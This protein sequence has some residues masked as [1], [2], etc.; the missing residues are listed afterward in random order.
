MRAT[1]ITLIQ[2]P[3]RV[4]TFCDLIVGRWSGVD[5]T[6]PL[7]GATPCTH[8]LIWSDDPRDAAYNTA[9]RNRAHDHSHERLFRADPLYDLIGVLDYNSDPVVRGAG[10]AIFL[11]QWRKPRHP[12]EG[13]VAFSRANLRY[14]L[15]TWTPRSRVIIRP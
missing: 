2:R 1:P 10:S 15:E 3:K 5:R 11:H 12:T 14:V 8:D 9:L 13:C 4:A 6:R 7:F